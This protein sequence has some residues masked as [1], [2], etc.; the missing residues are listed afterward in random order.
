M[1]YSA[2]TADIYSR[3]RTMAAIISET[4]LPIH[5]LLYS[6]L[7]PSDDALLMIYSIL[8]GC[9]YMPS[10]VLT[11]QKC[12]LWLYP[13]TSIAIL[14]PSVVPTKSAKNI[15]LLL[16]LVKCRLEAW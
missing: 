12:N 16:I 2:T 15:A 13:K 9:N 6:K 10:I 8:Q 4:L 14:L 1:L 5:T 7:Y 11:T 3:P